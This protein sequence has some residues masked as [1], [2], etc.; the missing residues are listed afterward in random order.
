MRLHTLRCLVAAGEMLA[1]SQS[2]AAYGL[3]HGLLC[4]TLRQHSC[5]FKI[6][7]DLITQVIVTKQVWMGSA[8][9]EGVGE[10]GFQ[11]SR[12]GQSSLFYFGVDPSDEPTRTCAPTPILRK[13]RSAANVLPVRR[14]FRYFLYFCVERS[15][16]INISPLGLFSGY[17]LAEP[18]KRNV[19]RAP[20]RMAP[21]DVICLTGL[22]CEVHADPA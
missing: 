4:N 6:A 3:L 15:Q 22:V 17:P 14:S 10:P 16:Y 9:G 1:S 5:F 21:S 19:Y 2:V 11:I 20:R 18:G 12:V 7:A 8:A 13:A